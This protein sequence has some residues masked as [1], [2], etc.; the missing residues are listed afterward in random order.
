MKQVVIPANI[1]P[2]IELNKITNFDLI[3]YKRANS[4]NIALLRRLE[5]N[6]WGFV[7]IIGEVNCGPCFIANNPTASIRKAIDG[8]RNVYTVESLYELINCKY[9]IKNGN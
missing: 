9:K 6:N 7:P 5:N 4:D 3:V 8:G 2:I 1:M